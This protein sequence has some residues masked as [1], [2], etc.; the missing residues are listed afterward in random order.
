MKGKMSRRE[1]LRRVAAA[2][3]SLPILCSAERLVAGAET[4]SGKQ[5]SEAI[6]HDLLPLLDGTR[7]C[8]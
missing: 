5:Q 1:M 7:P 4:E 6:H 3:V 8:V 2:G